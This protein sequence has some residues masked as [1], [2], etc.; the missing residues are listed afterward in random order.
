[1]ACSIASRIIKAAIVEA[2][3]QRR[4][5]RA[6]AFGDEG[7]VGKPEHVETQVSGDPQPVRRWWSIPAL[8][9]GQRF[10]C[11]VNTVIGGVDPL[12]VFF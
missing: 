5:R 1:M 4:I 9:A 3:R 7:D 12:D 8:G 10:A 2:T 11:A 6:S